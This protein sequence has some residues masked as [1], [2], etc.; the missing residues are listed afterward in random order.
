MNG[1]IIKCNANIKS[2]EI[3]ELF[4]KEISKGNPIKF[5]QPTDLMQKNLNVLEII[6]TE[7]DK[8]P[9]TEFQ[10]FCKGIK[11]TYNAEK[12]KVYKKCQM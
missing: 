9:A 11:A 7:V 4:E 12:G 3:R 1:N 8:M 5:A 10:A 2:D 6:L